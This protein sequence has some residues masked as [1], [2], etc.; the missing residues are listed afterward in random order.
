MITSIVL[1][2][3]GTTIDFGSMAPI[4]ALL[5]AFGAYG[6]T[7]TM[8]ETRA[9]MG[10]PKREHI[11][12]MLSAGRLGQQWRQQHGTDCR[13]QDID[14]I[15]EKFEPALFASLLLHA[16]LLPG[17]WKT[18]SELRAMK[19]KIG[20]TTGYNRTMMDILLPR[21]RLNGYEP[22]ALVCPEETGGLGRPYPYMLWRNLELL[23]AMSV[24]QTIKVGDTAADIQEGKNAGCISVGII[25]GSS[26]LGLSYDDFIRQD[27]T[28][29]QQ[30]YKTARSR[31]RQAGADYV[32]DSIEELPEL[33][34]SL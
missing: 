14:R 6:L 32:L 31:Y 21:A 34:R 23:G 25:K 33:A 19:I 27:E 13:E 9:P 28:T 5:M 18:V 8:E 3:A 15:Y 29:L 2:W 22:D 7:P 20:S 17:V 30:L 1:D 11:A 4:N 26:M 24:E 10:L 12:K 16:E